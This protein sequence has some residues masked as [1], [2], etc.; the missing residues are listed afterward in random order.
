M[1]LSLGLL[2][3]G[4][5][6]LLLALITSF[7]G[8]KL[9]RFLLPLSGLAILEG[10]LYIYVYDL[11]TLNTLSTWLFFGGTGIAVYLLLFFF[12]RIAAFF[13]GLM[14]SAL[15]MV[16]LV[17]AL[18][19]HSFGLMYPIVFT[20]CVMAGLLAAFYKKIG[21]IISTSLLGGCVAAYLGL[22]LYLQG[23]DA[24]PFVG[25]GNLLVPL[26]GFLMT[27]VWLI[28][29]TGF[30]LTLAGLFVQLLITARSQVLSNRPDDA[31]ETKTQKKKTPRDSDT[32]TGDMGY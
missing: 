14:G 27:R 18:G 30:A 17:Y 23:A 29:G 12:K 25:G 16:Y 20:L 3:G 10:L 1:E 15:F 22:Y 4:C 13:T 2:I 6:T 8:Y 32:W 26:E 7:F 21:V 31:I 5:I 28:G 24:S 19:L 9:A 11:L